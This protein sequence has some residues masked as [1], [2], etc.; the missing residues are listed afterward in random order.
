MNKRKGI[1]T[2]ELV[3]AAL[4]IGVVATIL[5]PAMKLVSRQNKSALEHL[6]AGAV[7]ANILDDVTAAPFIEVTAESLSQTQLPDWANQQLVAA[8]LDVSV[9]QRDG[10]KQVT[11][12][13]SWQG[14]G[15]KIRDKVRLQTWIFPGGSS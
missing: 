15:N 13:L 1:T 2:T 11:A 14:A 5:V 6:E 12:E 8:R 10:G 9:E 3:C 4:I 7:L